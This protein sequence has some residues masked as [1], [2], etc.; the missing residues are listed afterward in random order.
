LPAFSEHVRALRSRGARISISIQRS[1]HGSQKAAQKPC[2]VNI[3]IACSGNAP[4]KPRTAVAAGYLDGPMTT[5]A[6][7]GERSVLRS[8]LIMTWKLAAPG[9]GCE[10]APGA[11]GVS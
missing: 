4:C 3:T 9:H 8:L 11:T 1:T 2:S 7:Q 10:Y 6:F 5:A